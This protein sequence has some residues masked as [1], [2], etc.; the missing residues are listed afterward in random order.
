MTAAYHIMKDLPDTARKP[1]M[2]GGV[3][4]ARMFIVLCTFVCL[5]G[6]DQHRDPDPR[7]QSE[8]VRYQ[9]FPASGEMP[10]V[11]LDTWTGCIEHFV[12]LTSKTN[13][14]DVTWARRF[15]EVG[16]P[17]GSFSGSYQIPNADL[18][19]DSVAR[20]P[21]GTRASVEN[22]TPPLRCKDAAKDK[23]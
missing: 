8:V 12:K 16:L 1:N 15:I 18:S 5:A 3:W 23:K 22:L 11:L 13:S 10:A 14:E 7:L 21:I 2:A 20:Y 9:Y 4:E 19:K 6:C 17:T